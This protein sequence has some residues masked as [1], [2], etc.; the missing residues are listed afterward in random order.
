[1][2]SWGKPGALVVLVIWFLR[3]S[4]V[5]GTGAW[6]EGWMGVVG[7]EREMGEGGGE[8]EGELMLEMEK[9]GEEGKEKKRIGEK[10]RCIALSVSLRDSSRCS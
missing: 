10:M 9:S 4:S 7:H 5:A 6:A 1:M 8:R 2:G 3:M